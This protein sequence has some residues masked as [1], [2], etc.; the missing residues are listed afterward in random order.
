MLSGFVTSALM[1]GMLVPV[2]G[3]ENLIE[4]VVVVE[5]NQEETE[6]NALTLEKSIELALENNFDVKI[7]EV[8][9]EASLLSRRKLLETAKIDFSTGNYEV[10]LGIELSK[11]QKEYLETLAES[12]Y[13][14]SIIGVKLQVKSAY[15]NVIHAQN[16]YALAE[17]YLEQAKESYEFTKKR[18]DLGQIAKTDLLEAESEVATKKSELLDAKLAVDNSIIDLNMLLNQPLDKKWK[19]E[20]SE[21]LKEVEVPEIV[22]L[23]EHMEKNHPVVIGSQMRYN[24]A[25]TTFDVTK[26]FYPENV[27]THREAK[28]NF[29]KTAYEYEA[30]K[31]NQEKELIQAYQR[32]DSLKEGIRVLEK[33]NETISE[34]YRSAQ[35]R[36]ELGYITSHDLNN[37]ALTQQKM[38]INLINLRRSYQLAIAS[39]E[40]V[41]GYTFME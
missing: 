41:S 25:K 32:L 40:A 11:V 23:K 10:D 5:E 3:Q 21:A 24:I 30:T 13:D 18:L 39:L 1:M 35:L 14:M 8:D 31:L 34:V 27:F 12:M 20:E 33:S 16:N 2:Y 17:K 15:A 38:E 6:D 29:E 22:I 9:K 4:E 26:G 36:M 28:Q 37:I 7:A 19:F